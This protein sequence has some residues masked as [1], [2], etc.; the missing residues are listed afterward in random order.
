MVLNIKPLGLPVDY[1]ARQLI[2]DIKPFTALAQLRTSASYNC[3]I[4]FAGLRLQMEKIFEE[5]E[6][7]L[8][9]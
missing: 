8:D 5:I 4:F 7:G 1:F 3:Y 6:M 2:W 9:P